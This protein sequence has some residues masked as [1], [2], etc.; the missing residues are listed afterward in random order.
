MLQKNDDI[1]RAKASAWFADEQVQLLIGKALDAKERAAKANDPW[2][3]NALDKAALAAW[4][5]IDKLTGRL[6]LIHRR[7]VEHAAG[8][9]GGG[10]FAGWSL[11]ELARPDLYETPAGRAFGYNML[12]RIL[13]DIAQIEDRFVYAAA[14][15]FSKAA[16]GFDTPLG[17]PAVPGGRGVDAAGGAPAAASEMVASN[18]GYTAGYEGLRSPSEMAKLFDRAKRYYAELATMHGLPQRKRATIY[19]WIKR[20]HKE[21]YELSRQEGQADARAGRCARKGLLPKI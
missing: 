20:T 19:D 14:G 17:I 11:E 6:D 9:P 13:V 15:D 7:A 16:Q 2:T 10:A 21:R 1:L 5:A 4:G 18:A 8:E 12:A 3:R